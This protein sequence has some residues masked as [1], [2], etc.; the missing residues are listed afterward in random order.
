MTKTVLLVED[1]DFIREIA[2]AALETIG[3][4]NVVTAAT[5]DEAVRLAVTERPDAILL[6]VMMSVMDG[7]T[8]LSA[9]RS[10]AR[11]A[12]IP[13]AFITAKVHAADQQALMALGVRA[14]LSKPFDPIVLPEQVRATFGWDR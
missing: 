3:K 4:F 8:T 6:D 13:V 9:L 14:V 11:T 1:E 12:D 2:A 5:G 7:P 10:D